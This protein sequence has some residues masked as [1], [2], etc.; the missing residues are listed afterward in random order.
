MNQPGGTG[1]TTP[2]MAAAG[3]GHHR[4][5]LQLLDWGGNACYAAPDGTTALMAAASGGHSACVGALI[6]A[7]AEVHW[8]DHSGMSAMMLAA[9]AGHVDV[10]RC[11]IRQKAALERTSLQ[12]SRPVPSYCVTQTCTRHCSQTKGEV[13]LRSPS[14]QACLC[15]HTCVTQTFTGHC[16]QTAPLGASHTVHHKVSRRATVTM[17][18]C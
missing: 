13:I 6:A 16:V 15:P 7:G 14:R 1:G 9:A 18:S 5:T 8:H 4:C 10:L 17:I 2:L 11:L 3:G 12:A